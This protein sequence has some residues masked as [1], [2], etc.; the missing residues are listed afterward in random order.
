MVFGPHSI[1]GWCFFVEMLSSSFQDPIFLV[2]FEFSEACSS[3]ICF[4]D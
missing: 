1:W 4:Y 3:S 2:F